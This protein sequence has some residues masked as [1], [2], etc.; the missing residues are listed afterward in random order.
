MAPN[1]APHRLDIA[2]KFNHESDAYAYN[3]ET[4]LHPMLRNPDYRLVPGIWRIGINLRGLKLDTSFVA[5]LNNPGKGREL[6][7]FPQN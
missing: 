1:G 5:L 3:N 6:S 4:A 2:I 7:L